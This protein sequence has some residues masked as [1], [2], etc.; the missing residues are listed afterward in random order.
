VT[1]RG[2]KFALRG[3]HLAP[4]AGIGSVLVCCGVMHRLYRSRKRGSH[5]VRSCRKP[6]EKY[7]GPAVVLAFAAVLP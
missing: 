4:L 5:A 7:A 1:K 2:M 6:R 3:V